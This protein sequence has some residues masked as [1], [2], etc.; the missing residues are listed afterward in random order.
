MED[1][2]YLSE[3]SGSAMRTDVNWLWHFYA[4]KVIDG[5]VFCKYNNFV[6]ED[7]SGATDYCWCESPAS[8]PGLA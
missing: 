8:L 2:I 1:I 4:E 5:Q 7:I 3:E 6:G